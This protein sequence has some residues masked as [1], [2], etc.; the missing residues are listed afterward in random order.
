[1]QGLRDGLSESEE[2]SGLEH[3]AQVGV[4]ASGDVVVVLGPTFFGSA[5]LRR[6]LWS[7]KGGGLTLLGVGH[8]GGCLWLWQS[9]SLVVCCCAAL[10][11]TVIVVLR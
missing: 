1:M 11:S 3:F 10:W 6:G 7:E 9:F 4:G 8:D 2:D 5:V